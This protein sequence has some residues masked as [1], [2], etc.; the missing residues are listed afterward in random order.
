MKYKTPSGQVPTQQHIKAMHLKQIFLTALRSGGISRAQLTREMHL[1]FPS[2]SA[3]VD[4]LIAAGVIVESGAEE[5]VGRGRPSIMLRVDPDALTIPVVSMTRDGYRYTLFNACAQPI[6]EGFLPLEGKPE[7]VREHWRPSEQALYTPLEA[8][9][10]QADA[11][12]ALAD[13]VMT[14]P[15]SINVQG[16]LTSSA[17]R[18]RLPEDFLAQVERRTGLQIAMINNSDAAAYTERLCQP[19]PE[20]FVYVH[21]GKGVGAGII[22]KGKIFQSGPM[23]AGEIG[24]VSI[25][26]QGRPCPCGSRGCLERYIDTTQ[27]LLEAKV[28][29]PEITSFDDAAEAYR[30]GDERITGFFDEKAT[31]L[32]FGIS[33]LLALQPVTHIVLGGSI[34]KLGDRFLETVYRSAMEVGFRKYIKRVTLSYTKNTSGSDALGALWNYL[35]HEMHINTIIRK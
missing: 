30:R 35:E 3:L 13:L 25:D 29:L 22:R 32:A 21:V 7:V 24:H 9:I 12:R 20:D 10:A 4:E 15:G 23:R 14:V 19:L 11:P 5:S 34:E 17:L 16:T 27:L 33:N 26:Y 6:K 2:V 1:S 8:L 31:Q 28:L 18:L